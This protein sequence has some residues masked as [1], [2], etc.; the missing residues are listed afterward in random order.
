[1]LAGA[2]SRERLAWVLSEGTA[3]LYGLHPRKGVLE[4]GADADLTLVDPAAS[5]TI[6]GDRLYSKQR[7]TPWQ[8]RCLRGSIKQTILRGEV[9]AEDGA[10]VGQPRGRL[11]RARHAP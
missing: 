11:I 6:N 8:G 9:I 5:T 10:T 1:M 3:R 4:P 7:Q 2:L